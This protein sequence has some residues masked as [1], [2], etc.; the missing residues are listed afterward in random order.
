MKIRLLKSIQKLIYNWKL[1]KTSYSFLFLLIILIILFSIFKVSFI[2]ICFVMN[3]VRFFVFQFPTKICDK[4]MTSE[5]D[6]V[7]TWVNGSDIHFI[8]TIRKFDRTFDNARFDDKGELK[9]SLRSIEMYAPWIRHI[10]IVTNGQIPHWLDLENKQVTLVTHEELIDSFDPEIL[11]TFSSVVIE[12]LLH[13]IPNL[14][15]RFL[16]LN[17]DIFIGSEIYPDDLYLQSTGVNIFLGW[18]IPDCTNECPWI[19]IGDGSCDNICNIEECQFDGGDCETNVEV[20]NLKKM[21]P[22]FKNLKKSESGKDVFAKSLIY[23]NKFFNK[24]YGFKNRKVLAHVGFLLEKSII[25]S[26]ME[27]FSFE[28]KKTQLN[29]FR[30]TEDLQYAFTYYNFIISENFNQT[31][32]Q[33]FDT[34]DTDSSMTWSDREIRTILSKIYSLPLDWAAVKYF[35]DVFTNCSKDETIIQQNEPAT[36]L[37]YE[38]Y[39][40]SVIPTVTKH[41]VI[42]CKPISDIL[43]TNFAVTPKYKY[44]IN[45]KTGMHSNFKMLTSNVSQVVDVLDELRRTPK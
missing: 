18:P 24:V 35:E 38:R 14:S 44:H 17:D 1:T 13:K 21:A 5:I 25:E 37:V 29:R 40:N 16:Y 10:F 39:Q 34:F 8:E 36:T 7:Y 19:F 43:K 32:E 2:E 11:P 15:E 42:N 26:M 12:T 31:I 28:M 9:Y 41:L 4:N 30:S 20:K 27:K 23:S 22:K 3:S 6:L 33:I 45:P